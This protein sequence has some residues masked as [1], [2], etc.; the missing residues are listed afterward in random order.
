[1]EIKSASVRKQC[2]NISIVNNRVPDMSRQF[3]LRISSNSHNLSTT[4]SFVHI[5]D[6]GKCA[7]FLL[8][9]YL[10]L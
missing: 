6:D 7:S 8:L 3:E 2:I 9:L 10:N 4:A 5:L 1:M